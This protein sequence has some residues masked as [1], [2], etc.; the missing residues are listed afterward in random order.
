VVKFFID[1]EW[2]R[3][4]DGLLCVPRC[5][6]P[7][8]QESGRTK[9][10]TATSQHMPTVKFGANPSKG[11]RMPD[12]VHETALTRL[13]HGWACVDKGEYDDAIAHYDEAIALD[14]AFAV[15][16]ALRGDAYKNKGEFDH[17]IVDFTKAIKLNPELVLAYNNRG[18]TYE[19]KGDKEQAIADFRKV[20]AI[21][22]SQQQAIAVLKRLGVK[23]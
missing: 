4:R 13:D 20:L 15:A 16:Y 14:P 22:P 8:L 9:G 7:T 11:D 18:H 17:A 21:D 12:S 19:M 2:S 6:L 23:P 1:P 10:T 3:G 5:S